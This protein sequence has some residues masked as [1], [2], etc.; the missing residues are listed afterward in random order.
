MTEF[1]DIATICTFYF[2]KSI[3]FFISGIQYGVVV[4]VNQAAMFW[5]AI[6]TYF[7]AKLHS[8]SLDSLNDSISRNYFWRFSLIPESKILNV[9]ENNLHEMDQIDISF[10]EFFV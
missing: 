1:H 4:V 2:K 8:D 7:S 6:F 5:P 3:Q 9:L 10:H